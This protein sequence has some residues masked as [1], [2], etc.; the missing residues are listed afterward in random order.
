MVLSPDSKVRV[1]LHGTGGVGKTSTCAWICNQDAVRDAFDGVAFIPFGQTP[2]LPKCLD[3]L[4]R[5]LTGG[6]LSKEL[7]REGQQESIRQAC[8]GLSLLV[9]LDDVWD[10][11]VASE[12][13]FLDPR[14]TSRALISS[15]VRGALPE[16]G[17]IFPY[18]EYLEALGLIDDHVWD[19]S[20]IIIPWFPSIWCVR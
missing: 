6:E 13:L 3:L 4:Y 15:R 19:L 17:T 2:S 10:E 12:F 5:Q 8:L 9:V 11:H 1:G 7:D 20:G 18:R 14:T 16:Q